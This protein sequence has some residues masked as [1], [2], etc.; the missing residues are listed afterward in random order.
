MPGVHRRGDMMD[1]HPAEGRR[2]R[3]LLVFAGLANLY[4]IAFA[5]DA[6]FSVIDELLGANAPAAL[7]LIRNMVANGVVLASLAMIFVLLF[8]PQL[9]RIPFFPPIVFA[10]WAAFGAPPLT[11]YG[12]GD[13]LALSLSLAQL[14]FAVLAFMLVREQMGR[15]F[16][17]VTRL[18]RKRHMVLRTLAAVLTTIIVVPLAL[19][20]FVVAA[21]A[22]A[23]QAMTNNYIQFTLSDIRA[24]ET[25]LTKDGRTVDLV[26]VMHIGEPDFYATRLP[27]GQAKTLVLAEGVSDHKDK[28]SG[29]FSYNRLAQVLGLEAQPQIEDWSRAETAAKATAK[30]PSQKKMDKADKAPPAETLPDIIHADL[31]VSDFHDVTVSFLNYI[32]ALYDSGSLPEAISQIMTLNKRYTAEEFQTIMGDVLTRRNEAVLTAFDKLAPNYEV[33]VIP[34]GGMHMPGLE[35]ALVARGYQVV[36]EETTSVIR[37]GTLVRQLQ[38]H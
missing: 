29:R 11:A 1:S 23:L 8:V 10:L 9:P 35:A 13:R 30:A 33:V 5:A 24:K 28:L 2:S 36:S 18:P 6:V 31:D 14:G 26:A 22:H 37:Y 4:L 3:V 15:F 27:K 7:T 34:W 19:S 12:F 25:H 38:R 21:N 16:L 17:V 20:M 32:G